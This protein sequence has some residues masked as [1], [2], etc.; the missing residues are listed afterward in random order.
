M[1]KDYFEP[2]FSV[3][4]A[5]FALKISLCSLGISLSIDHQSFALVENTRPSWSSDKP[6]FFF[7]NIILFILIK[8]QVFNCTFCLYLKKY[9]KEKRKKKKGGC[10]K[11]QHEPYKFVSR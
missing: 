5:F 4:S 10:R 9:R 6:S 8:K 3:A 2:V 1:Q 11:L 7:L